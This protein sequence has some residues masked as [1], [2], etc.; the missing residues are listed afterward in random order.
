MGKTVLASLFVFCLNFLLVTTIL[1]YTAA[2][3]VMTL[4]LAGA[5]TLG[6]YYYTLREMGYYAGEAKT[7]TLAFAIAILLFPYGLGTLMSVYVFHARNGGDVA[8][9]DLNYLSIS[10]AF[11]LYG[12][13]NK[14]PA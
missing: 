2:G 13:A 11:S 6:V 12:R 3:C 4:L 9:F 10:F 7:S 5:A 8:S 14:A 1:P